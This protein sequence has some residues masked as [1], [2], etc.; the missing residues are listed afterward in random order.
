[1][2]TGI[3]S[4]FPFDYCTL[5]WYRT[6]VVYALPSGVWNVVSRAWSNPDYNVKPKQQSR[7]EKKNKTYFWNININVYRICCLFDFIDLWLFE[8]V[9]LFRPFA[10]TL[11]GIDELTIIYNSHEHWTFHISCT[12]AQWLVCGS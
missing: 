4:L 11:L 10:V 1:M 3:V 5:Q 7:T 9:F 8:D 2:G 6:H 12:M